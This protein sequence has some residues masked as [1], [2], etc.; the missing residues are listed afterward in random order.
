MNSPYTAPLNTTEKYFS[1]VNF[2]L[3]NLLANVCFQMWIRN[4]V[5]PKLRKVVHKDNPTKFFNI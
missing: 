1:I 3:N 5:F 2:Y 4:L